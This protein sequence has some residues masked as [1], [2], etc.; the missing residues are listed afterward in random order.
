MNKERNDIMGEKDITQKELENYNDVFADVF[1]AL[2]FKKEY[3]IPDKLKPGVTNDIV[4]TQDGK[5]ERSRD[6]CKTYEEAS[7]CIASLGIEN[8]TKIDDTMP[9]RV[10]GYDYGEY[11]SQL[12]KRKGSEIPFLYPS[13]TVVLNFNKKKWTG[14]K[15]LSECMHIE[16]ELTP[17]FK[18]YEICVI[19]VCHLSDEDIASMKSDFRGI[20]RLF[21]DAA[22]GEIKPELLK[23]R[24]L[25]EEES[26]DLIT[27]YLGS[28]LVENAYKEAKKER[29]DSTMCEALEKLINEGLE[30][31]AKE[32]R[33]KAIRT[34]IS[35]DIG[36][37]IIE[38]AGYTK[39]EIEEARA[40]I[41]SEE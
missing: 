19:D 15:K 2:V 40:F 23:D 30:K 37:D 27:A 17:F 16:E 10:L 25:H 14:P 38:K 20:F 12:K 22:N 3:I 21:K 5:T 34:M 33:M 36:I 39:E 11:L 9:I 18:D 35:N 1:N 4:I 24:L 31:G 32:E 26:L 7:F 8:Q 28:D 6:V 29:S 41:P 13:I